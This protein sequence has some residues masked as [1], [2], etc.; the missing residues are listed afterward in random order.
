MEAAEK[1]SL[2]PDCERELCD[3]INKDLL[4]EPQAVCACGNK[5]ESEQDIS[6]SVCSECR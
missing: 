6:S 1:I 5:L 4:S 2:E 3:K